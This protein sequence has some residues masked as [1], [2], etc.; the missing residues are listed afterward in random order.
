[1]LYYDLHK[2]EQDKLK[3]KKNK[4][5]LFL[6]RAF[7]SGIFCVFFLLSLGAILLLYDLTGFTIPGFNREATDN[8]VISG[9]GFFGVISFY[10]FVLWLEK[11]PLKSENR[12]PI[13]PFKFIFWVMLI[14]N[15]F[16]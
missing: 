11:K 13:S 10:Y 12:E 15:L 7:V 5:I 1:M 9:Y 3:P 2:A 14:K 16:N 4:I 8:I 6:K